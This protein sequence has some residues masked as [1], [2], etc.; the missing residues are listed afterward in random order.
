MS[1]DHSL[2]EPAELAA[3][4]LT[5]ALP[6]D[7]RAWFEEHLR[8]PCEA[9]RA[10]VAALVPAAAALATAA[11][12][13]TPDPRTRD[14]VLARAAAEPPRAGAP[15]PLRR[16]LGAQRQ[17]EGA[18]LL[19]RRAADAA[20]EPADVPGVLVRTLFV[21]PDKNQFTALVRM[22]PGA[23]Y[24]AHLH[25]GPEE[26]LVLEGD[27]RVGDEVLRP[28]DYQRAPAGSRHGVQS[29]EQGCLILITSS[30]TDVFV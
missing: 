9:C 29:T 1:H 25:S 26:C 15:S 2:G 19:V 6:S 22:R 3:L 16:H 23:A 14:A 10:E 17:G 30:L 28:G 13:L 24:P 8:A 20:W 4:Y 18:A 27:L 21:D 12:P 11:E 7:Q 5:G